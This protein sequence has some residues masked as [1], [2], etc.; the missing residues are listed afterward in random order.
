MAKNQRIKQQSSKKNRGSGARAQPLSG[1]SQSARPLIVR[2]K[3]RIA[4]EGAD[5]VLLYSQ[6][7]YLSSGGIY[8]YYQ[9]RLNSP[10]DF[11]YTGTGEQPD[12]YDQWTAFYTLYK[13][14]KCDIEVT[15]IPTTKALACVFYAAPN[16]TG[17]STLENALSQR[18]SRGVTCGVYETKTL[19]YSVNMPNFF[20]ADF[21]EF[22]SSLYGASVGTNPAAICYGTVDVFNI[23]ASATVSC[24]IIVQA[25]LSVQFSSPGY[26]AISLNNSTKAQKQV[27]DISEKNDQD[28][29]SKPKALGVEEPLQRLLNCAA[30][31]VPLQSG[32][33]SS[34]KPKRTAK[35]IL[36]EFDLVD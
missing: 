28:T 13:C 20:G 23:D 7:Y 16:T 29:D 31:T 15:I 36:A 22:G 27:K 17:A 19:R 8:Q 25:K 3:Q 10:N 26:L 18:N 11:D 14:Y 5:T 35:Q 6:S 4:P 2:Q 34:V 12:G 21:S 24:Y 30:M 33:G 9:F 1:A 32:L